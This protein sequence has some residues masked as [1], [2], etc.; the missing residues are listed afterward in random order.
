MPMQPLRATASRFRR[1]ARFI[2]R[3]SDERKAWAI[4]A[5][6]RWLGRLSTCLIR[7]MVAELVL[8]PANGPL[9]LTIGVRRT[10]A[11]ALDAHAWLARQGRVVIGGTTA[12][13]YVPLATWTS[14]PA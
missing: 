13:E 12:G 1:I 3:G 7:A 6:G 4:E 11:G 2:V 8:D 14:P 9:S 5:T 10:T